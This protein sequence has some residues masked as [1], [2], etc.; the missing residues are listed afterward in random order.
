MDISGNTIIKNCNLLE[1]ASR[2]P[3]RQSNWKVDC[4]GYSKIVKAISLSYR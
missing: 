3:V 1:M 4:G 2:N